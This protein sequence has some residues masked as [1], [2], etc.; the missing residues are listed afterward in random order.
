MTITKEIMPTTNLASLLVAN[1]VELMT[2][3]RN[4]YPSII[5]S[6]W[7]SKGNAGIFNSDRRIDHCESGQERIN[8]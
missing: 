5:T 1:S 2:S 3:S 7:S 6:R 8:D 4:M